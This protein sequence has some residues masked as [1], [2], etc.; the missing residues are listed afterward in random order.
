VYLA[1]GF[2]PAAAVTQMHGIAFL[3]MRLTLQ[4]DA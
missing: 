1:F 2:V 3:P 4:N